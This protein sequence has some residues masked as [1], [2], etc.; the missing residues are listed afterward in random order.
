MDNSVCD[1]S[2]GKSLSRSSNFCM[3]LVESETPMRNSLRPGLL[4]NLAR[5][6]GDIAL[7]IWA[8]NEYVELFAEILK[9]HGIS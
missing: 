4:C 5:M 6:V 2:I 7:R 3:T 9:V 1:I 8:L